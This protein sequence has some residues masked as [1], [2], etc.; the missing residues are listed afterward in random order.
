MKIQLHLLVKTLQKLR[1]FA[2]PSFRSSLSFHKTIPVSTEILG[3][4]TAHYLV[5]VATQNPKLDAWVE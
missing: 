3:L 1:V 5:A 4:K 2:S